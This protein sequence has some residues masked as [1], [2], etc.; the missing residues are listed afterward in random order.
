MRIAVA[1]SG[2]TDSLAALLLLQDQGYEVLALHGRFLDTAG[3]S[4]ALAGLLNGL[5]VTFESL[6]LREAFRRE[7]IEPFT[8]AYLA[9]AT[10]NP[11]AACNRAVKF[12]LLLDAARQRGCQALAT[13]H[14]ARLENRPDL[15]PGPAT[16]PFGPGRVLRRGADPAKDQS[17]FL[18]LVP[19]E[20]L[21]LAATPL[22]GLTKD[23][24]RRLLAE[25]GLAP[26]LPAESQEIC[27]VPGDDYCAF[28]ESLP[29]TALPGPGPILFLDSLTGE[30]REVGH[31]QGLWRHTLGQRRGLGVAWA[32]PLYVL[33]KDADRNALIVGAAIQAMAGG[34]RA[35]AVNVLTPPERW[36]DT[37]LVQTR[38]R[39]RAR[40]ADVR[41]E[42]DSMTILFRE[43]RGLP[44]PGQVAAA[45]HPDGTVLAGGVIREVL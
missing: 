26:P 36:P 15:A 42:G 12:G 14:Y 9:G 10:P 18:S 28:L 25:R 45:Y 8:A 2:G 17:Y 31:H 22:G 34:C 33:D 1:V 4:G 30:E 21:A 37:V 43:P 29:D 3:P 27:F 20:R 24:A 38:Y 16:G 7:V 11:C 19:A 5:G 39:Q 13:G 23:D 41:L 35:G 40:P 32:E 44:A 6:D